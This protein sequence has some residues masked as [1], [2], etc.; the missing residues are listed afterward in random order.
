MDNPGVLAGPTSARNRR[1]PGWPAELGPLTT[2]AGAVRLRPLKR[3]DGRTWRQLR[4]RDRA[5]I[6]CWDA[7]SPLNWVDRHS[8]AAWRDQLMMLRRAAR[9]G[10]SLPFALTVDGVF[11]G[12]V[13]IGGIQRGALRAGWIGYWVDSTLHGHGVAS[14]GVALAVAHGLGPVGLHRIEATISPD[15]HASI[16]VARHIGMREEGLLQRYLDIFGAWR[17]HLLFAITVEEL[18]PGRNPAARLFRR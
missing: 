18:P 13:T 12:Q 11:A 16:G 15:N 3:R 4:L 9:H 10:S 8:P 2:D 5:L 1:H 17:D 7:T 14:A 6:E